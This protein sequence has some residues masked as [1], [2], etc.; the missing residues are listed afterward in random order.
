LIEGVARLRARRILEEVRAIETLRATTDAA[1]RQAL[2]LAQLNAC[3]AEARRHVPYW[4]DAGPLPD[5]FG[6]LEDF[7]AVVPETTRAVVQR[8]GVRLSD[9]RRPAD[10]WRMTGG[11]T[12]QPVRLPAWDAEFRTVR[13]D[14]WIGRHWYGVS[15]DDPAFLLWGHSHLLGSGLKGRLAGYRRR[16]ADRLLRYRRFS[17]Y[18]LREEAMRAAGAALLSFRPRW[19]VGYSVALDAFAAANLDRQE[20]FRRLGLRVAVATA[21]AFPNPEAPERLADLL[22]CPVAMEYGSVETGVLAH[23][24]PGDAFQVLWHRYLVEAVPSERG[25]RVVVTSLF[26]RCTPLFRY[27][28]GD[29]VELADATPTVG[30]DRLQ[31]VLGRCNEWIELKDGTRVHSEVFSHAVRPCAEVRGFQVVQAPDGVVLHVLAEA[32]LTREEEAGVRAR[33]AR[34]HPLLG[35]APIER[36]EV[37]HRSIAGKTPMIVRVARPPR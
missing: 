3:W 22:G 33:L 21:E 32:P 5:R 8:E 29:E 36:V 11:S 14:T 30:A 18:D 2:Q 27:D 24:A 34:V 9:P 6:R 25:R 16:L 1:G 10:T 26:P 35:T 37:L 12:S 17:A 31:R 4:R 20:A 28:M 7:A 23:T 13:A 15:P 19:I